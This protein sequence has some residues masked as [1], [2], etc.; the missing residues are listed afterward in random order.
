[1]DFGV[2]HLPSFGAS[3]TGSIDTSVQCDAT[4]PAKLSSHEHRG[5]CSQNLMAL[6]HSSNQTCRYSQ[7]ATGSSSCG[8]PLSGKGVLARGTCVPMKRHSCVLTSRAVTMM[9]PG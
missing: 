8:S 4:R 5:A 2:A 6:N 9:C 7:M 3:Q 1:M